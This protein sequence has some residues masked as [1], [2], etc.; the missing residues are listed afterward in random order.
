MRR[1]IPL[2]FITALVMVP[3]TLQAQGQK[4]KNKIPESKQQMAPQMSKMEMMH[5]MMDMWWNMG[6]M[7]QNM[8]QML[9]EVGEILEKGTLTPQAQ[10]KLGK[11]MQHLSQQFPQMF[12]PQE[13]QKQQEYLKQL[14]TIK[15]QLEAVES[16]AKAK[17][18]GG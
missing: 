6:V 12:S 18:P 1:F 7:S 16:G 13:P 17:K 2:V 9:E 14:K 11:V 15:E 5:T 8:A 4:D 10:Q 3:W